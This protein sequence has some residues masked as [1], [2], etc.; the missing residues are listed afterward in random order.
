MSEVEIR[1]VLSLALLSP[2]VFA[3]QLGPTLADL[4]DVLAVHVEVATSAGRGDV[5]VR[6]VGVAMDGVDPPTARPVTLELAHG[7]P[8]ALLQLAGRHV[9]APLR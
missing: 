9:V 4:L 7:L 1:G 8:G 3:E 5:D 2:I 6:V